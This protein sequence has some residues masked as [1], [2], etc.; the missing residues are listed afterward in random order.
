MTQRDYCNRWSWHGRI[1]A[2][3][4][5]LDYNTADG[6]PPEAEGCVLAA[7]SSLLLAQQRI[8]QRA[9]AEEGTPATRPE[10]APK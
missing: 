10:G 7:L 9:V 8:A 3:I 1:T 4:A 5:A 6:P 2:A